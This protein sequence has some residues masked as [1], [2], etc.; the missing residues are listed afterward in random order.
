M[1]YGSGRALYFFFGNPLL[2]LS[3]IVISANFHL[4]FVASKEHKISARDYETICQA[5]TGWCQNSELCKEQEHTQMRK[6][7]IWPAKLWHSPEI[8]DSALSP[9]QLY[10]I[11]TRST[12]QLKNK[13]HR[14]HCCG[15][16]ASLSALSHTHTQAILSNIC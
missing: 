13:Q 2:T 15:N 11:R 3:S 16:L 14:I 9:I 4:T 6:C 10:A 12:R 1:A 8:V 7:I 5:N